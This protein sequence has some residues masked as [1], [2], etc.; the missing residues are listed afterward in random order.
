M[1][2]DLKYSIKN[3]YLD[4]ISIKINNEKYIAC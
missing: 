3:R 4:W 2:V 1:V